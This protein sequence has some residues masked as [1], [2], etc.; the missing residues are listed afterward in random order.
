MLHTTA[1]DDTVS[2]EHVPKTEM[3]SPNSMESDT[4]LIPPLSAPSRG[5]SILCDPYPSSDVSAIDAVTYN[6]N[7]DSKSLQTTESDEPEVHR[8][9]HIDPVAH[10]ATAEFT[11]VENASDSVDDSCT[12]R[13][14]QIS[15]VQGARRGSVSRG[16]QTTACCDT[17]PPPYSQSGYS[18]I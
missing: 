15:V 7:S 3:H 18:I 11:T 2:R 17:P 10:Q 16:S 14:L 12:E 8:I 1:S 5:T 6:F 9:P 4:G 13:G